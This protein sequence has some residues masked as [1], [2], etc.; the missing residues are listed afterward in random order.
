MRDALVELLL[1]GTAEMPGCLSYVVATDPN[2]GDLLWITEVW[3]SAASHAASL[4][5]PAVREAMSKGRS[6]IAAV[7]TVAKTS[8]VPAHMRVSSGC[9]SRD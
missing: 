5:F 4:G 6:L 3:E 2:D 7:A 9:G 1:S 8:P